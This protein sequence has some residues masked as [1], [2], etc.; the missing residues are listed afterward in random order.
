MSSLDS[1]TLAPLAV[2]LGLLTPEQVQEAWDQLGPSSK[3]S[4]EELLRWAERRGYM[5]PFQSN[6]LVK[7]DT[8]GYFLGG[9]RILYK[10]ASGSFGRVYRASDSGT[11][12]VVAIKL[13]RKKW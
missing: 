7:G 8:D 5:T 9:Y 11:G 4:G 13:L 1:T 12:R 6:K 10:I 3:V 2:R